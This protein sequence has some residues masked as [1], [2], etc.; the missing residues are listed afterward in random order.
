MGTSR[1]DDFTIGGPGSDED[2]ISATLFLQESNQL[3]IEKLGNRITIISVIIPCVICAILLF[4]YMDIKER[5]ANVHDRGQTEVLGVAENLDSKLNAMTVDLAGVKH[6][7]ETTVNSLESET[8]RLGTTKAEKSAIKEEIAQV[9]AN[10]THRTSKD[11]QKAVQALENATNKELEALKT[12]ETRLSEALAK[13]DE[14]AKELDRRTGELENLIQAMNAA[15]KAEQSKTAALEAKVTEQNET[16]ALVQKELSLV[17]IKA[18][19]LE[20]TFIDRKVLDRELKLLDQ[21]I[22]QK[23]SMIKG[24]PKEQVESPLPLLKPPPLPRQPKPSETIS[25]KDLLQ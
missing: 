12:K 24:Q 3:R 4:A 22:D 16:M 5:M 23:T 10:L 11:L 20:Q 21:K 8:A 25:E 7:F 15:I 14:A 13:T 19:T 9:E 2:E 18:D 17:K 6:R 1:P